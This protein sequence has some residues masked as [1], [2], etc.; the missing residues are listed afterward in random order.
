MTPP[1]Q[2]ESTR[3][4]ALRRVLH[5]HCVVCGH[6][7]AQGLGLTFERRPDGSVAAEFAA[8]E[9]LQGYSGRLHGGIIAALLDGAMTNCLFAQGRTAFTAQLTVRY[10]QPVATTGAL[11]IRAWLIGTRARL[12]HVRAELRADGQVKA[13]ASAKFLEAPVPGLPGERAAK[14]GQ[15]D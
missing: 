7:N 3:L 9:V 4:A 5:P 11:T 8:S 14:D 12:H 13:T 15:A 2:P 6:D 10:H 1:S